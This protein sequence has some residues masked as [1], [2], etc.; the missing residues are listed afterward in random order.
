MKN[1]RK[2]EVDLT[3]DMMNALAELGREVD[4]DHIC[5]R[6]LNKMNT[7]LGYV[8]GLRIVLYEC[9]ACEHLDVREFLG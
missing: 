1:T 4:K 7:A 6:C 8:A 5:D 9:P 2:V 3:E